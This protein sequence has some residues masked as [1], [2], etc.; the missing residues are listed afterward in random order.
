MNINGKNEGPLQVKKPSFF[1]KIL[2]KVGLKS[3]TNSPTIENNEIQTAD[4]D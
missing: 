4:E 1:K 2:Y 3:N